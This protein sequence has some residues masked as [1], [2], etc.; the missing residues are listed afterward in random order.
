MTAEATL[1]Q[2]STRIENMMDSVRAYYAEV[3]ADSRFVW[4]NNQNEN[5]GYTDYIYLGKVSDLLKGPV[6]L[7][8]YID[9]FV[10]LDRGQGYLFTNTGIIPISK[11][12]NMAEVENVIQTNSESTIHWKNNLDFSS[13]IMINKNNEVSTGGYLMI[14]KAPNQSTGM[15]NDLIIRLNQ[16]RLHSFVSQGLGEFD[17]VVFDQSGK[18]IYGTDKELSD[19]CISNAEQF[20]SNQSMFTAKLPQGNKFRIISD[21][22]QTSGLRYIVGYNQ[23]VVQEGAEKIISVSFIFLG[24]FVCII[25]VMLLG[26]KLIYQPVNVLKKE[27]STYVGEEVTADEFSFFKKGIETLANSKTSL[28]LVVEQ[29]KRQLLNLFMTRMIHGELRVEKINQNLKEFHLEQRKYYQIL[30]VQIK[31]EEEDRE[32]E[33]DITQSDAFRMAII[34]NMP[35]S[36]I[37]SLFLP[38]ISLS[39]SIIF[40]VGANSEERLRLQEIHSAIRLF[41]E[42]QYP[43]MIISGVSQIF[44]KL[45]HIRIA[46]NESIEAI[47]NNHIGEEEAG[48][49]SDITF[50]ENLIN[51][52]EKKYEYD[53]L[54]E[55]AIYQAVDNRNYSLACQIMN[56][57][58]DG[59]MSTPLSLRDRSYCLN[60]F[61]ISILKVATDAGLSMEQIFE[62]DQ[63][64]LF[65]YF[66]QIYDKDK[67]CEFLDQ[68]IIYVIIEQLVQFRRSNS[69]HIMDRVIE[70]IKESNGD[71]TLSECAQQLNYHPSYIWKVLKTEKNMSFMD[72]IAI[73]K[74]EIAKDML[75]HTELTVTQIAEKLNYTN[76]QNFIRFFSKHEHISPGKYKTNLNR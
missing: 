69:N 13:S 18:L 37:N 29:Q 76:T 56:Q 46:F 39:D 31:Y 17:A 15:E 10:Y 20:K 25:L 32:E 3:D 74:L 14:L 63:I 57:F 68:K 54:L 65:T 72:F 4:L 55:K 47:K 5:Q 42:E 52:K 44:Q 7:R 49:S 71:I 34:E 6:Y 64:N 30:A 22:S 61:L 62:T 21:I 43:C 8:D 38:P 23:S 36:I 66:N 58:V 35:E 11:V 70:L 59:I 27:F 26:T 19:Y 60:R 51:A 28:E 2:L 53:I 73:E 16:G 67:I 48:F 45:T 50:Y 12:K 75:E 24:I 1:G 9:G 40:I 33:Q 41:I